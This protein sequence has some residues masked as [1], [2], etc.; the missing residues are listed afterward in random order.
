MRSRCENPQLTLLPQRRTSQGSSVT[1]RLRSGAAAAYTC[2]AR[3]F[4]LVF[5]TASLPPAS[6]FAATPSLLSFSKRTALSRF[7]SAPR[8]F[9]QRDA[10]DESVLVLI[11]TQVGRRTALGPTP[12]LNHNFLAPSSSAEHNRKEQPS[13]L[14]SLVFA[15]P[16]T[17]QQRSRAWNSA[18]RVSGIGLDSAAKHIPLI[19]RGWFLFP[20]CRRHQA[21][22]QHP[23]QPWTCPV[24]S[25]A[26]RLLKEEEART[27]GSRTSRASTSIQDLPYRRQTAADGTSET[28]FIDD[29]DDESAFAD[30]SNDRESM[31]AKQ[32]PSPKRHLADVTSSDAAHKR[33]RP[34]GADQSRTSA[35]NSPRLA[36]RDPQPASS[37]SLSR[38]SSLA[39][40]SAPDNELDYMT[41]VEL[42]AYFDFN[43]I[44]LFDRLMRLAQRRHAFEDADAWRQWN[45]EFDIMLRYRETAE[46]A[47]LLGEARSDS[48]R[49]R[50]VQP[51]QPAPRPPPPPQPESAT[52]IAS[53]SFQVLG[54][55]RASTPAPTNPASHLTPSS[56]FRSDAGPSSSSERSRLRPQAVIASVSSTE[57]VQPQDAP[58]LHTTGDDLPSSEDDGWSSDF[59]R[60]LSQ[61]PPAAAVRAS[62]PRPQSPP[63]PTSRLLQGLNQLSAGR[64]DDRLPDAFGGYQEEENDDDSD[65]FDHAGDEDEE[66]DDDDL[67][68]EVKF[69]QRGPSMQNTLSLDVVSTMPDHKWTR[70]VVYT[71]RHFFKLKRFRANQL[72]A[73]NGTLMGR[74]VFVLMPTGGGKS[75]C[76]QLPAC[77]DSGSTKGIT[78]VVSPLL[79]LIQDQV[80][81]LLSLGIIAAK[82][83]GDMKHADK[84]TVCAEALSSQSAV[85]LIYVTPE[86][87]RQSNQAKTLLNDLHRRKRIARFVVDEAHCVS[88]WG[89]DF[90]P[91]YTELG[92]LRDDYPNVP[93]MALTATANERVIKDVKEHLHM[94][95]VIQLSQSFNRPNLEY[96]VRPKPG[97][98]V[99]EEISSLIL[100][101]HKD[102]CGIIYCFSRESCETV[103]HDLSTKYGI[104]AHH[105]HAKLSAD[106]R[107]MVQQKWQQ[108][109]FRVIVATIAFGMGID[110]PDVRFVIHHSAP[111]SLEGYYQETGR[112][113]RDGKSSVCILYYNY[114]DINKMKSMIEKEEDKSPEAKERAIQSLDDIARFCN[115][116]I[117][118][119]RVQ[120][121]R[122][123]GETFSAA[124]CHNTCDNC[125]RKGDTIRTEDVTEMAKKAVRLVQKL[126]DN[127]SQLTLSYCVDV[128]RGSRRKEITRAGHHQIEMHGA[129][130]QLKVDEAKRLFELLCAEKV[131]RQRML[132]N[133]MGFNNAYLHVGPQ[134]KTVLEGRKKITMQFE[135][136][137]PSASAKTSTSRPN[138]QQQ[139]RRVRDSDFA[140][141]DD[142][143]HDISH[144]SLSPRGPQGDRSANAGPSAGDDDFEI[145]EEVLHED[146]DPDRDSDDDGPL[147][148]TG[149]NTTHGF[150]NDSDDDDF[151]IDHQRSSNMQDQCFREL[152]KLNAKLAEKEGVQLSQFVPDELLYEL[153]AFLPT[154]T[155]LALAKLE[156]PNRWFRK[157]ADLAQSQPAAA[158]LGL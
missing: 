99:L 71:M 12:S 128:F 77:V 76:Y 46:R 118:C 113:G 120:V 32:R 10:S 115:N 156:N 110:K 127:R 78:I 67:P 63:P 61:Q 106:D 3:S 2:K 123:F 43:T 107:A 82:L 65:V 59:A 54:E 45:D 153:S 132:K 70:D 60:Q 74:D 18:S 88:Q 52:R 109:K 85:R 26:R 152:K 38:A 143:A 4:I 140:E 64:S 80:R 135:Q 100:T 141:F 104:S 86:F 24:H 91:H 75:L 102:Q 1:L 8:L 122:Y 83:T 72:E 145:P 121:L 66:E 147:A 124:M 19:D 35:I 125:C 41:K 138:A 42:K 9:R 136:D 87:I 154:N 94:K 126:T 56:V 155:D 44:S 108:N 49:R 89:H 69:A 21:L 97:N 129:G 139:Q 133:K 142:D 134:A 48:A 15:V 93:I 36:A 111:K 55:R 101:S 28:I 53:D 146:F 37:G 95:D 23:L 13:S 114:A 105:Y 17:S 14:V 6:A 98:K 130:S 84:Q 7:R 25:D 157:Y 137:G 33:M 62:S 117:E 131:F 30:R 31:V 47:R 150:D 81:H 112:A 20:F 51:D 34:S 40:P 68:E 29:E 119:R 151:V 57:P 144:V 22:N 27:R 16:S 11:R 158:E 50:P 5:H 58:F 73:I 39:R 148:A 96:Q 79:S 103:A 92:A 116:K 90:R 149:G